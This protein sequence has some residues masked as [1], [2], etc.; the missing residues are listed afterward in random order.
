V[1]LEK[2]SS[3]FLRTQ[4]SSQELDTALP[5]SLAKDVDQDVA[6]EVP[7]AEMSKRTTL[8]FLGRF[9]LTLRTFWDN[10]CVIVISSPQICDDDSNNEGW[11]LFH[12]LKGHV[13]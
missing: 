1:R 13:E 12:K 7:F 3:Q 10:H 11:E 5:N 8:R 9:L 6:L 4:D 2:N